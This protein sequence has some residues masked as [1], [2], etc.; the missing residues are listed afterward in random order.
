MNLVILQNL[1]TFL[2]TDIRNNKR[3]AITCEMGKN[4][5]R[6][7]DIQKS[8]SGKSCS[9]TSWTWNN[10]KSRSNKNLY[11]IHI[12]LTIYILLIS[13]TL[14]GTINQVQYPVLEVQKCLFFFP[15][16]NYIIPN[17]LLWLHVFCSL[18]LRDIRMERLVAGGVML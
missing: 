14:Q 16:C 5:W 18:Y 15:C 11:F 9:K 17:R 12:F 4:K 2:I 7:E 3:Q 8:K 1:T 6:L 10:I 13:E